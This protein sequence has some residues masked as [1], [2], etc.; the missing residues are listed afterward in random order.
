MAEIDRE[1]TA[2]HKLLVLDT[3]NFGFAALCLQT[4]Y[5]LERWMDPGMRFG[6]FGAALTLVRDVGITILVA[7]W[8][9]V[10]IMDTTTKV[11]LAIRK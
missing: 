7:M 2:L 11:L 1:K 10:C 9:L 3:L 8:I 5:W 4:M 6:W